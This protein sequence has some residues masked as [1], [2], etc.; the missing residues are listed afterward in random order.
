MNG[1]GERWIH[2]I[3]DVW[4]VA[5]WRMSIPSMPNCGVRHGVCVY[6]FDRLWGIFGKKKWR[7][8]YGYAPGEI[9]ES[10][11]EEIAK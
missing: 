10:I 8:V 4:M 6:R 1:L 2:R 3:M 5:N 7:R 11:R 9:D